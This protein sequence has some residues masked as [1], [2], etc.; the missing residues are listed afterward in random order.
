MLIVNT[1]DRL[2]QK[3]FA[4]IFGWWTAKD[5]LR[6]HGLFADSDSDSDGEQGDSGRKSAELGLGVE[7]PSDG[8]VDLFGSD[9]EDDLDAYDL[10]R[11]S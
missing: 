10:V 7:H 4:T 9:V 11:P 1:L 8:D 3:P 5:L 2:R 6:K